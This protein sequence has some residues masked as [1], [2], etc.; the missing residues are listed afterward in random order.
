MIYFDCFT[1]HGKRF[2]IMLNIDN[3]SFLCFI[4]FFYSNQLSA[5]C[6]ETSALYWNSIVP[7][8]DQNF[9]KTRDFEPWNN[10][11]LFL[12]QANKKLLLFF[13]REFSIA[14]HGFH[15]EALCIM[16]MDKNLIFVGHSLCIFF[17]KCLSF[18]WLFLSVLD[19][20]ALKMLKFSKCLIMYLRS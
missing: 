16:Q 15:L 18:Y 2:K 11:S 19:A 6:I 5:P 8:K 10:V 4:S 13:I 17:P 12:L 3:I 14:L 9:S 20:Y 7:I 1:R